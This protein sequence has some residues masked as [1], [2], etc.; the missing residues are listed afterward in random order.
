[1]CDYDGYFAVYSDDF[2]SL[3]AVDRIAP[4]L[5]EPTRVRNAQNSQKLGCGW[6]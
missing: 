6:S 2:T 5:K 1:M 3:D 4:S